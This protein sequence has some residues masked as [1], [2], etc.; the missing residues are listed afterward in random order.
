MKTTNTFI[1]Q[2]ETV[3]QEDALKAFV[4]KFEVTEQQPYDPEFLAKI[5]E[6]QQ[7][8]KEGKIV[9]VEKEELSKFLG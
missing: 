9:K 1:M 5:R 4:M 7:Q 3:E 2:P 8:A 6:S